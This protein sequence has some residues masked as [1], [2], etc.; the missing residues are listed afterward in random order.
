VSF[1]AVVVEP[2][3]LPATGAVAGVDLGIKDFAVTSGGVKVPN[4]RKL[5]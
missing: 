5:S 2:E 4:P 1:A 3:Q